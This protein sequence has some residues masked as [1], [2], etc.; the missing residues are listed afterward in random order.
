[1]QAR[2]KKLMQIQRRLE[3]LVIVPFNL[4]CRPQTALPPRP[5]EES[6]TLPCEAVFQKH[7]RNSFA[8]ITIKCE[9]MSACYSVVAA[10]AVLFPRCTEF[11]ELFLVGRTAY[12]SCFHARTKPLRAAQAKRLEAQWKR[13]KAPCN[14][15]HM[16]KPSLSP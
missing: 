13:E 12:S 4:V 2:L 1:M 6:Q 3:Q 7:P 15:C 11:P 10:A 9:Q 5:A 16:A 14:W 8:F